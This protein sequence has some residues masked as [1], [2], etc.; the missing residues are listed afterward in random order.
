M[1]K[2]IAHTSNAKSLDNFNVKGKHGTSTRNQSIDTQ[3]AIKEIP[4]SGS[5]YRKRNQKSSTLPGGSNA[6]RMINNL[7]DG[8]ELA[9]KVTDSPMPDH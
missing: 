3:N 8:I 9:D 6:K 4:G 2:Q 5:A 7:K 1:N